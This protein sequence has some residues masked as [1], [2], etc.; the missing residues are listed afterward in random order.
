[1]IN[2]V[3]VKLRDL[4]PIRSYPA[5]CPN[6]KLVFVGQGGFAS[7]EKDESSSLHGVL[8]LMSRDNMSSLD[9]FESSYNRRPVLCR[10]YLPG[11]SKSR[12]IEIEATAYVMDENKLDKSKPPKPPSERYLDII[13]KVSYCFKVFDLFILFLILESKIILILGL[14]SLWCRC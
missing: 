7:I 1:M 4:T 6:W 11:Q 5:C 12:F 13:L 9:K 2:P 3:S 10:A 8:H 14:C